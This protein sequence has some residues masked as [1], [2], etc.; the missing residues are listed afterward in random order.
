MI[1]LTGQ[2]LTPSTWFTPESFQLQIG[3]KDSQATLTVGPDAP[4]VEIGTWLQDDTEPGK[5]IIWRVKSINTDYKA[6]T[7]TIGLEH[8]IQTLGDTVIPREVDAAAMGG[9]SEVSAARA[10]QYVLG[11]QQI[12]TLGDFEYSQSAPY[13]FNG[14]SLLD[15]LETI[16]GTLADSRWEYD[17]SALPFRLHIR[18]ADTGTDSELRAGRNL[19]TITKSV[20]KSR[21][22]T[23]IYP[24]GND[25]LRL[26]G[27]GYLEQNA[28]LY[29]V[30]CKVET[31]QACESE[32]QLRIWAED[33]LRRHC[34]PNVSITVSGLDLSRETG[35]ALDRLTVGRICR[36]PMPE[37]GTVITEKITRLQWRDKIKDPESVTVTLANNREDVATISKERDKS[38]SSSRIATSRTTGGIKKKVQE[39]VNGLYTHITDVAG[40]WAAE[41][42]DVKREFKAQIDVQA[43]RIGLVV[44]GTGKNAKIRPAQIVSSINESGSDILISASKVRLEGNVSLNSIFSVNGSAIV[45]KRPIWLGAAGRGP[46]ISS[47]G[48]NTPLLGLMSGGQ[49]VTL[50]ASDVE[51]MVISAATSADG[52]TLILKT[53]DYKTINFSKATSLNGAWSGSMYDGKAYRVRAIQAGSD[54]PVATHLSPAVSKISSM[55]SY[56]D[57][58]KLYLLVDIQDAKG[59]S[60]LRKGVDVTGI[61]DDGQGSVTPE[62]HTDRGAFACSVSGHTGDWTVTLTKTWSSGYPPFKNGSY[63]HIFT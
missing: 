7:R 6:E 19:S 18:K 2:T 58:S 40:H 26:S 43:D 46:V 39:E 8:I 31:N 5:G 28:G 59:E 41:V 49:G 37:L 62:S 56:W 3:E 38:A 32:S 34:E 42:G 16:C 13:S 33:R 48:I 51:K 9:G 55:Y 1:I 57:G 52:K 15:A 47:S 11:L 44:E 17:L 10:V 27:Q 21:M 22:Y 20:D 50:K 54:D 60:V 25:D 61:Y 14:D 29:G 30:I 45:A 53:K 36:V 4:A 24:V 63:P 12:W 35:E 23:R